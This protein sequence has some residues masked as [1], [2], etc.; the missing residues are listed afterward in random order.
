MAASGRRSAGAHGRWGRAARSADGDLP[1]T[2]SAGPD[3]GDDV[4]AGGI[5]GAGHLG[6]DD[7]AART[8]ARDPRGPGRRAASDG[9]ARPAGAHRARSPGAPGPRLTAARGAARAPRDRQAG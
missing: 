9:D 3:P 8:D 7:A 4:A 6:R 2:E 1:A 5:L